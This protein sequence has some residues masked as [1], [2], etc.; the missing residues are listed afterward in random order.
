MLL[1]L[2]HIEKL[3]VAGNLYMVLYKIY[4]MWTKQ[5]KENMY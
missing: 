4:F 1:N 5:F 3:S 2:T